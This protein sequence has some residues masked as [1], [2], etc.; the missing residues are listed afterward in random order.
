MP[1]AIVAAP[2]N[3]QLQKSLAF[4]PRFDLH[5]LTISASPRGHV[6]PPSSRSGGIEVF[7][8]T[9]GSSDSFRYKVL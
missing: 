1:P 9:V 7:F 6:A 8:K 4:R 2:D 3:A 5:P